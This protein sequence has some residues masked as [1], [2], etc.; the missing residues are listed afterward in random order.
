MRIGH[1][2]KRKGVEKNCSVRPRVRNSV[3]TRIMADDPEAKLLLEYADRFH[4]SIA[5]GFLSPNLPVS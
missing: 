5:G 3:P 4:F 2:R 1:G